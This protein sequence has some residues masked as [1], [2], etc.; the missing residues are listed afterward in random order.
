MHDQKFSKIMM[1]ESVIHFDDDPIQ[2]G[3]RLFQ[4]IAIDALP[5]LKSKK[6]QR[7]KISGCNLLVRFVG[8]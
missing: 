5:D 8:M 6:A 3:P 2:T 4:E 7:I 1:N